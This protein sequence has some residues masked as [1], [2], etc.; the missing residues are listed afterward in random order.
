M[1]PRPRDTHLNCV[2]VALGLLLTISCL[3]FSTAQS[4][5]FACDKAA[6]AVERT[7]CADKR[8]GDLDVSVA[9]EFKRV[10]ESKPQQRQRMLADQRRWL[11]YRDKRCDVAS[12]RS[13]CIDQVYRERV[14]HLQSHLT[15]AAAI[16]HRLTETESPPIYTAGEDLPSFGKPVEELP[17][18]AGAQNPPFE[19]GAELMNALQ[20]IDDGSIGYLGRVPG[21]NLY[22]ITHEQGSGHCYVSQFFEVEAGH[23]RPAATPPLI[24]D[25]GETS[26]HV[27]RGY[28]RFDGTPAIVQSTLDDGPRVT[29]TRIV[30]TWNE[31][32]APSA[33]VMTSFYSPR[34]E[35]EKCDG[36][37]CDRWQAGALAL[38]AAVQKSPRETYERLRNDLDV[39]QRTE[40][41][42]AVDR[43]VASRGLAPD[44]RTPSYWETE[45]ITIG[46]PLFLPF[47]DDGQVHV[48]SV[49]HQ[50]AYGKTLTG[51]RVEIETFRNGERS[52]LAAFDV[53]MEQGALENIS[54]AMTLR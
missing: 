4:Q 48:A 11:T 30:V 3:T 44:A 47:P 8:L 50:T 51:W 33:C 32:R 29:S 7:I 13:D 42:A 53:K 15:P 38:V 27:S 43:A 52:V 37:M 16:C 39:Q 31:D 36:P 41:E 9:R 28:G 45:G 10:L 22:A 5:S 23:A 24:E 14:R 40:F 6:T 35:I 26:C 49:G 2:L 46:V 34:F 12:T 19:V 18:W 17:T 20:A 25:A 1:G 21:T 54:V